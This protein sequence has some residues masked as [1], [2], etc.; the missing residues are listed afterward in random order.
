MCCL[1]KGLGAPVGS[2]LAGASDVIEAARVERKRLG[3]GMRQ[4]GILAAAG[5]IALEEMPKRLH[6][7][8]ANARVLAE[9]LSSVA[10]I[11]IDPQSVQTNIVIFDVAGMGLSGA[12]MSER[13]KARGVLMN[14]IS[15]T[16]VRAVT[17]CDVAAQDCLDAAKAVEEVA[18]KR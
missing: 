4:A 6:E 9:K 2:M 17:H 5:L 3:G 15:E 11:L 8:H 18:G 1:S 13:L 7:D 10:G 16:Q 14:A 12:Q